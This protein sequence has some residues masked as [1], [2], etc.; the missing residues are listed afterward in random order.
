MA[1]IEFNP[2]IEGSQGAL[3]RDG[4]I[5]RQKT[6]RDDRGRIIGYGKQ[7]GYFIVNPRNFKRDPMVGKELAHHNLWRDV[8]LQAK[9]ELANPEKRL[10]WELR[11]KEQLPFAKGTSPD[12][13]APINPATGAPKRY[14]Q[15]Y[16]FARAMIYQMLKAEQN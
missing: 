4:M 8:C 3:S 16:S 9:T 1:K 15:L 6:Y 11:F 14:A 12:S 7:E 13:Q 5:T 2:V 10:E